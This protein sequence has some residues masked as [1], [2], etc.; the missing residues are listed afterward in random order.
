MT[1]ATMGGLYGEIDSRV[2]CERVLKEARAIT[3]ALLKATPGNPTIA[4]IDT[5]LDA[6]ERWTAGGAEPTRNDRDRI[7]VGLI[8][9]REL[10]A[11]RQDASGEL[12]RKLCALDNDFK[13]WPTD[14]QAARATDADY[15]ARFGL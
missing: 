5:Q 8:A 3:R 4:T 12:A 13:E 11:D 7:Q 6:M 14:D 9:V 1:E 2:T 15:W 10:D